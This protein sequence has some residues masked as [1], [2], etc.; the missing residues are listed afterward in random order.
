M[1]G[2][3]KGKAH[4]HEDGEDECCG[5]ELVEEGKRKGKRRKG[6]NAYEMTPKR[7]GSTTLTQQSKT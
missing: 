7:G 5:H 3:G 6:K 1:A 2:K 4:R